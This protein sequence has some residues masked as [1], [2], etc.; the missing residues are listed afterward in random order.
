VGGE[1]KKNQKIGEK[2]VIITAR[3]KRGPE[4][5]DRATGKGKVTNLKN[6]VGPRQVTPCCFQRPKRRGASKAMKGTK[7][8]EPSQLK[9]RKKKR[10]A[11][12]GGVKKSW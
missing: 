11:P 2:T 6:G 3:A 9:R 5:G 8:K 10:K 12:G 7:K 4:G 1:K